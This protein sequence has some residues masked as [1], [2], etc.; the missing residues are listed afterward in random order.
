[1]Q[2]VRGSIPQ[3]N[4]CRSDKKSLA[5]CHESCL[6][7][8]WWQKMLYAIIY[9]GGPRSGFVWSFLYDPL[10]HTLPLKTR[11]LCQTQ[12]WG[13]ATILM[14]CDGLVGLDIATDNKIDRD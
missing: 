9:P 13:I 8:T 10:R 12:G 14:N 11:F 3:C 1:M 6:L 4:F 2:Y 7:A 5:K